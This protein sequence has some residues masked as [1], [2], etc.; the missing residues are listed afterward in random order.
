MIA[1]DENALIC[2]FAETYH[3]YNWRALPLR[4][5]AVLAAG[6]REDSRIRMKLSGMNVPLNTLLQA[7]ATD[8][9]SILV[10]QQTDDGHNGRRK[11]KMIVDALT[12]DRETAAFA[13]GSDFMKRRQQIIEEN[14]NG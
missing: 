3:I 11:P 7:M 5:S 2:D 6:L 1:R 12:G 10:W 8:R 13:S 4:T 9:L 14:K